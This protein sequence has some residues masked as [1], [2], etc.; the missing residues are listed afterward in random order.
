AVNGA[1]VRQAFDRLNAGLPESE[2]EVREVTRYIAPSY[3]ERYGQR[4]DGRPYFLIMAPSALYVQDPQNA[5]T[6]FA[7]E[8]ERILNVFSDQLGSVDLDDPLDPDTAAALLELSEI[9]LL[10]QQLIEFIR[11]ERVRSQ[12]R[13]ASSRVRNGLQ[14]LRFYNE[15]QLAARGIHPPFSTS[16]E[17][18]QERRY[19]D[20]LRR[21]QKELP[22]ALHGAL[23]D[24]SRQLNNDARFQQLLQ[25][26]LSGIKSMVRDTVQREIE[27]LLES[28]GTEHWDDRDVTYDSLIWNTSGVEVPIKRILYQV[29]LTM[30]EAVSSYMPELSDVVTSELERTLDAHG[31]W[32]RL[33][34]A[35]Y[36]QEYTFALPDVPGRELTLDEGYALLVSR[37]SESFRQICRQATMYELVRPSRSI[38]RRLK[39]G[40][41]EL[42]L[43]EDDRLLDVILHGVDILRRELSTQAQAVTSSST[44]QRM[45]DAVSAGNGEES[46][47]SAD[48]EIVINIL[49]SSESTEPVEIGLPS[50]VDEAALSLE[51]S[52]AQR[53]DDIA[54]KTNKI[55][56][57]II[58]D[59]FGDDELLPR[60]RRL[61]W[62]EAT[63]VERDY[64]N[65]L[66]KPMIRQ[67]DRRLSSDELRQAMQNDLESVSDV[68]AL[69][70]TWEGLHELESRMAG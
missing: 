9:P 1:N 7:S 55:F 69:M 65:H 27:K 14:S 4:G 47:P 24:L 48:E 34:H 19:E 28:Y 39:E 68:E 42:D 10:R 57:E 2:R 61:F 44:A 13:E 53:L 56:T 51:S 26:T 63:K 18:L 50:S 21:Q 17:S 58:D 36:G 60:L 30:Q 29:E 23:I 11:Q 41:R 12:L 52:Y 40:E 15:K 66:V 16:W 3:W 31:V 8:T 35:A 37:I 46:S 49:D 64:N 67:H 59:L 33:E 70:R 25:P 45:R 20:L 62:L 5:P 38:H 54:L 32:S 22:R 43:P 6:E